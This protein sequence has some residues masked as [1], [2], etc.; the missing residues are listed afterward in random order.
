MTFHSETGFIVRPAIVAYLRARFMHTLT[1]RNVV[2]GRMKN[3]TSLIDPI[4]I[5][6]LRCLRSSGYL[7][8][9]DNST[10]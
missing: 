5:I 2:P 6:P 8:I 7:Y 4:L 9:V 10:E 3:R 1:R